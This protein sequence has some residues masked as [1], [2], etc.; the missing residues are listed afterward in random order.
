MQNNID[1]VFPNYSTCQNEDL[2]EQ[3]GHGDCAAFADILS[4]DFED[5][6]FSPKIIMA[7]TRLANHFYVKLENTKGLEVYCD[8]YGVFKKETDILDRY[9]LTIEETYEV[10]NPE[11]N[12]LFQTLIESSD[13][14]NELEDSEDRGEDFFLGMQ[15]ILKS[16]EASLIELPIKKKKAQTIK[17]APKNKLK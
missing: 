12:K 6:G 16:W 10:K 14:F 15:E 2:K 13:L 1:I 17:V 4:W 7:G 3:Y 9:S 11:E 5:K 8:I